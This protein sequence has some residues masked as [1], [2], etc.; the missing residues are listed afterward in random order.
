MWNKNCTYA[1]VNIYETVLK[2][3]K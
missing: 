1:V 3:H 2:R